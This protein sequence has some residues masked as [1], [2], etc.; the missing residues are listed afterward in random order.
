MKHGRIFLYVDGPGWNPF[1]LGSFRDLKE[2]GLEPTEGMRLGFYKEDAN[3]QGRPTDLLFDGTVLFLEGK[4]WG[5][6]VDEESFR[7][8]STCQE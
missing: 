3:D 6:A 2:A 1:T 5:A 7:H 8:E 4:G